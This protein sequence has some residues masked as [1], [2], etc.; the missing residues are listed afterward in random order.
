MNDVAITLTT[1]GI[2]LLLGL[3]TDVLGRLTPLPR[4]T[5]LLLFGVAIGPSGIDVIPDA[6]ESWFPLIADAALILVGFTLGQGLTIANFREHGRAVLAN[7]IA[8]SAVTAIVVGGGLLLA[9]V[10]TSVALLLGSIAIAT[11]PAAVAD[12]VHAYRADGPFTRTLLGVVAIDDAW[13]LLIFSVALSTSVA[14]AS[15]G[16][17]LGVVLEALRQIGGAGLLGA[18]IG[19]PMALLFRHIRSGEPTLAGALGGVL[20]CGGLALHFELSF[21][22][23]AMT[24][25]AIV[26]NVN[27]HHSRP[28]RVVGAVEWPLLILFFVLAG[29]SLHFGALARIGAIGTG[30]VV[31]RI[32]GR[33][34]GASLG[35][36]VSGASGSDG[37]WMGLALLP[38]AGVALGLALVASQRLPAAGEVIMPVVVA[39]TVLFELGGPVLTRMAL[40]RAGETLDGGRRRTVPT[41]DGNDIGKTDDVGV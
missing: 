21:L 38:H 26:A 27:P 31:L 18:A 41:G 28:F 24:V 33:I 3:L 34:G 37:L 4:V 8:V 36:A 2:L 40:V 10:D 20:L 19:I 6:A 30:Y 14:W 29:A 9:G 32:L 16:E 11:A 17:G 5:L 12:V 7:S 15:A 25:G 39:A 35:S 22:L 1:I 13:G 23:C